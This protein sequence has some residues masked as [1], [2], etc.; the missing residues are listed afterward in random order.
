ML[1]ADRTLSDGMALWDLPDD[2]V[3]FGI[4]ERWLPV[5]PEGDPQRVVADLVDSLSGGSE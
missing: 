1:D 5:S 3:G 2:L 4:G